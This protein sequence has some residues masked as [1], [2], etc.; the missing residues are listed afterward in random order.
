[1][2]DLGLTHAERRAYHRALRHSRL[3]AIKVTIRDQNEKPVGELTTRV[4]E[5]SVEVD[6]SGQIKRR[7]DLRLLD[8]YGRLHLSG[9][10]PAPTALFFDRFISV[11]RLDYVAELDEWVE[12]PVFWGPLTRFERQGALVAIEALGKEI[13]ALE[14]AV[15]WRHFKRRKGTLAT[16]AIRDILALAGETRFDLPE[17]PGER[18]PHRLGLTRHDEAWPRAKRIAK[19]IDRQMFYDGRGRVRLRNFPQKPCFEFWAIEADGAPAPTVIGDPVVT[20]DREI[21]RNV[22]EVLGRPPKGKRKKRIRGVARAKRRNPLSPHSLAR[23]DVPLHLVITHENDKIRRRPRAR[24]IAR[25]LLR[26]HLKLGVH[27]S[28]SCLPV[29]HLEEND[30]VQLVTRDTTFTFRLRSFSIPLTAE[31]PMTI[32]VLPEQPVRRARRRRR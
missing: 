24:T 17:L 14:P 4:L 6:C 5:G 12:C 22:A 18:L 2:I 27:P 26:N 9:R 31:A 15:V 28:F 11:E 3:M 32:G 1:M 29:P 30:V 25:R 21:L 8:P 10:S 16:Q 7:L 19:S 13:L 23:N 20:Y